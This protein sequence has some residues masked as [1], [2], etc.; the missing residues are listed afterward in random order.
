[1]SEYGTVVD[2][3]TVRFERLLP[4]P[5]E[6]VWAY[7][8]ESDKRGLWLASGAMEPRAGGSA[9]L[10]FRH[11]DLTPHKEPIPERYKSM[12]NG[13]SFACRVLCW[14][15]PRL[16]CWADDDGK[17]G[18]VTFELA[19]EG[20]KVRLVLTHRRLADRAA[21]VSVSGGWHIHLRILEDRLA[22]R[23]PPPFWATH[24]KFQAE[25]ERR[26]PAS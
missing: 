14:E 15:P 25:Y 18:E 22:G 20:D 6:R 21:Q 7:L 11:A 3:S 9:T 13:A 1:M 8:T 17:F 26:I 5:I 19:P 12:E 4:G 23:E 2:A 10:F 24:E 16:L